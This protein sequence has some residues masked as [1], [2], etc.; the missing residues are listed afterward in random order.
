MISS[1]AV[2]KNAHVSPRS[3]VYGGSIISENVV[4]LDFSE[5]GFPSRDTLNKYI[6]QYSRSIEFEDL[7]EYGDG[8][9]IDEGSIIR[10][11]AIIYER[12]RLGKR[13]RTG[14]NVLIRENCV[15]GD[16]TTIGSGV[17]IDGD[18]IIGRN[19]S[20]QSGVYIP[21]KV[22]IGDNVFIGPRAVFTNDRYPPS[23]KL[24]ETYVEDGVVIGANATIVAGVRIGEK[25]VV[26][27]GSVVT[28][29]VPRNTVV[30]GVPARPLMSREE[31]EYRKKI[32]EE[33]SQHI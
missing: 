24:V 10:S 14:H 17:I 13:V 26:A 20:I 23:R 5:I 8:V 28:R 31:Y 2:I 11:H 22:F 6:T 33:S 3:N 27:A 19:V 12:T 25:A 9:F 16:E 21:P 18:V 32:Y 15:V 29:D 1:R 4:I 30:A 7:I